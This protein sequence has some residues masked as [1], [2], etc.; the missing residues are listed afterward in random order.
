MTP[1]RDISKSISDQSN[2]GY[3][4]KNKQEGDIS[5][6]RKTSDTR[7]FHFKILRK[8]QSFLPNIKRK[9]ERIDE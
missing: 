7:S 8:L 2:Y 5:L 1:N 6:N 4:V 3:V 9:H